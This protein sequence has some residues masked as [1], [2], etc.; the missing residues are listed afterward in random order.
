MK[1]IKCDYLCSE[2][3]NIEVIAQ[4]IN[5]KSKIGDKF[6]LLCTNCK[7]IKDFFVVRDVAVYYQK[8]L[9]TEEKTALEEEIFNILTNR[10]KKKSLHLK[11]R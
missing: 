3:G 4:N 7:E 5:V 9:F 1:V 10:N 8:L 11:M 2:C 6:D